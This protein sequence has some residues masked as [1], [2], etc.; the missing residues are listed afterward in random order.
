M[1]HY[2]AI[3]ERGPEGGWFLTFPPAA[4]YSF[5]ES[6]EQ[7]VEQAQD[8]LETAAMD[9]GALPRSIEDGARPP[10]ALSREQPTIVV[11]IPFEQ[12]AAVKAAA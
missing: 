5:A 6:A 1:L 10:E 7:I 2:Y 4:G 3:A 12:A 11:V 8:W 9:G